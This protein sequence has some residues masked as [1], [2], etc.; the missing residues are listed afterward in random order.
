MA[1]ILS[2]EEIDALLKTVKAKEPEHAMAGEVTASYDFRHPKRISSVQMKEFEVIHQNFSRDLSTH[3]MS[4][5][6]TTVSVSVDNIV[7]QTY[8][9]YISG[10]FSPTYFLSFSGKPIEGLA[11][12]NITMDAVFPMIDR[13]LGGI[14]EPIEEERELTEIE[15]SIMNNITDIMC[16]DI[17]LSW[18]KI[19]K[20][21]AHV[22]QKGFS[23]NIVT[24]TDTNEMTIIIMFD[25]VIGKVKGTFSICYPM[26]FLKPILG[27]MAISKMNIRK[28]HDEFKKRLI[29]IMRNVKVDIGCDL[30][31]EL[32]S[33]K[34]ILSLRVGNLLRTSFQ[35]DD[36]ANISLNGIYKMAGKIL[37]EDT[38]KGIKISK[39]I[40]EDAA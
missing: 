7:N 10:I 38:K 37:S 26:I 21:S 40:G 15:V 18:S 33:A 16:A 17:S 3:L 27:A 34:I 4:I 29:M 32:M 25:I 6:R 5:F 24:V 13:M 20:L 1:E 28:R 30:P 9:E 35:S 36:L 39:F 23:T 22:E 2:Q 8:G 14:G 11:V 12:I 31:E 19:L